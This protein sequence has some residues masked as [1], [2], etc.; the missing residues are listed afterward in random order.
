MAKGMQRLT[1][2]LAIAE[3]ATAV[4]MMSCVLTAPASAQFFFEDRMPW[5]ER[6]R[7]PQQQVPW[8][9]PRPQAPP[10]PADFSRAPAP[11]PRKAEATT[12]IVVM[13]DSIADWLAYGLEDAFSDTPE[14]AV[15]R[16]HKA[17][18]GLIRY[19]SR[20]DA[21]EWTQV[22]RE[23]IAAEK[24]KFIVM[25]VG[26]ADRDPIRERARPA[27]GRGGQ[28]PAQQ[29][30]PQQSNQPPAPAIQ[31]A[32]PQ[33]GEQQDDQQAAQPEA[34]PPAGAAADTRGGASYEFRS[35]KWGEIY[36]QRVDE[37]IA[38]LKSAGVP[39][40]WVGI[41]SIRGT[42]STSD[43]TYL[44]NLFRVRAERAG[45]TFVDV[46]DGFVDEAGRYALRGPDVEGQTRPLRAADGVH[47]TKAGARKLAH[48]VEREIRRAMG[49]AGPMALP[50]PEPVAPQAPTAARP[51]GP[52]ARPAAGPVIP[53]AAAVNTSDELLG[54][55]GPRPGGPDPLATRVLVKGEPV[56]A[57]TGRADDFAWPR[58]GP[59]PGG[60]GP[61]TP[62][63]TATAPSA[64]SAQ[65][66]NPPQRQAE[67]QKPRPQAQARPRPR[68]PAHQQDVPRPPG[69]LFQFF[70]R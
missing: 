66:A 58:R 13:G 9:A 29:Q 33:R 31:P 18:S 62:P 42:R 21:P 25:L 54:A 30:S 34:V 36:G 48:Y 61:A 26:L 60:A 28:Q 56:A 7:R 49:R 23:I 69:D 8:Y 59:E 35:E 70:R 22:A 1:I 2:C 68:A 37:M 15:V 4:I 27:S 47:F 17:F 38:V 45:I 11:P 12:S 44:N 65:P 41:P 14:V 53:L 64:P 55:G 43:V 52:V 5:S 20:R 3:A 39:V 24:P 67:P 46:W 40:L 51:A 57:P 63:V 10:P 32:A 50:A 16:K 6:P 19:E